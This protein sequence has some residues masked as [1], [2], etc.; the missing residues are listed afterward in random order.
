MLK[1]V[2]EDLNPCSANWE[3]GALAT[4]IYSFVVQ[5]LYDNPLLILKKA[6]VEIIV[7]TQMS[8]LFE[9]QTKGYKFYIWRQYYHY[10]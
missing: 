5:N 10:Y 3:F 8:I 7:S 6:G 9:S 1:I 4:E 2:S